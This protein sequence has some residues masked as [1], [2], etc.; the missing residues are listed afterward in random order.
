MSKENE[1]EKSKHS[2]TR[3]SLKTYW[4]SFV[5]NH[6]NA[7]CCMVDAQGPSHAVSRATELGINP[8]G[9][10]AIME[11][12]A[13]AEDLQNWPKDTLI[14]REQLVAHGYQRVGDRQIPAEVICED[15]NRGVAHEH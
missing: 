13:D 6:V 14:P 8:G 4:L 9:E 12:P 10:V 2:K 15:C 1:M 3:R 5:K 7:G 11:L